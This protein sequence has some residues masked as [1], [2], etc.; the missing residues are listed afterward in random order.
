MLSGQDIV[1][2]VLETCVSR[3]SRHSMANSIVWLDPPGIIARA[4]LS[5]LPMSV[6][7]TYFWLAALFPMVL[8]DGEEK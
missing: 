2:I 3:K 4:S 6:P 1:T 7:V 8:V 5:P